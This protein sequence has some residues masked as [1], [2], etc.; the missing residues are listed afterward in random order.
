MKFPGRRKTQHYFPVGDHKRIPLETDFA[1]EEN[2]YI[3]GIEQLIVDIEAKVNADYLTKYNI[4]KGQSVVLDDKTIETI[5][6]ELSMQGKIVGEFAGGT[7]GNTLHNYSVL[8]DSR[9][10]C[11]AAIP[12]NITVGE[13]AFKYI[14]TTN[15]HVDFSYLEPCAG[16]MARAICFVS[17][18]GERSF[19]LGKGIMNELSEKFI[20]EDVISNSAGLL[21]TSY[22]L[23]DENAP[24]FGATMKAVRIAKKNKVPVILS[25]GTSTL[26]EEKKGFFQGFI[27][28]YVTVIAMNE[29]EA[30]ALVDETDPF[31][32]LDKSLEYSDM[33]FLTAGSEGLYIAGYTDKKAA[34]LTEDKIHSKSIPE[35]N[36]YEYS[37]CMLKNDCNEPIK[38]FSHINPYMGGPGKNIKNTNGAG[39]A[40]LAALLHDISANRFHKSI[41]PNSPKHV[42]DCLT[43]SSIH[44][45]C[46]YANRVSYEVLIQNSPRLSRGLPVKED[47]LENSYWAH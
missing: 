29:K 42:I 38:I 3:V 43:Y 35:Y 12:K 37:R 47:N 41:V 2:T 31:L 4:L 9:S 1:S 28:D 6:S 26:I 25:L 24:L 5:Y 8:S 27:R 45:I 23:R 7:I 44:Q 17:E 22:L 11:L 21:I 30:K 39:D 13:Y 19:V 34:R 36:K 16:Q 40:A 14:C 46:K 32:A 10:V 20:P 33:A 15:S 18:D